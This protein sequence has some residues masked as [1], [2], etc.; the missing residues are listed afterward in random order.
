MGG[1]GREREW[2][3]YCATE[4]WGK[5]GCTRRCKDDG[6]DGTLTLTGEK[7]VIVP[8]QDTME[9]IFSSRGREKLYGQSDKSTLPQLRG[10]QPLR[11]TCV[12]KVIKGTLGRNY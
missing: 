5:G 12:T 8:Q 7:S 3:E 4:E 11:A 9:Y 1:G 2:G 10:L 6:T